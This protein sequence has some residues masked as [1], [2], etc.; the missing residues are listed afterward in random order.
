M[1]SNLPLESR[2]QDD[3]LILA[4]N[5]NDLV[6]RSYICAALQEV[7]EIRNSIKSTSAFLRNSQQIIQNK[8]FAYA[9]N[10]TSYNSRRV[11]STRNGKPLLK[12]EKEDTTQRSFLGRIWHRLLT[13]LAPVLERRN[14]EIAARKEVTLA[15]RNFYTINGVSFRMFMNRITVQCKRME[16]ILSNIRKY[17][18]EYEVLGA[19][20]LNDSSSANGLAFQLRIHR[21]QL[22]LWRRDFEYAWNQARITRRLLTLVPLHNC[23]EV[24]YNNF[25][26]SSFYLIG[27][28]LNRLF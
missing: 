14:N 25:N 27:F 19:A 15:F 23:W 18:K 2:R 8:V 21:G 16:N 13:S 10:H 26:Y 3:N 11:R 24:K 4:R 7:A 20:G 6:M 12:T 28:F 17:I 1:L 5:P 9:R 22:A